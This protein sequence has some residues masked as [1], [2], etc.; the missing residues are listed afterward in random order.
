[1]AL[2]KFTDSLPN[3]NNVTF[4]LTG[5]NE[6]VNISVTMKSDGNTYEEIIKRLNILIAIILDHSSAKTNLSM[7]EKIGKLADLGV[8]PANIARILGKSLNYV[9]ASLS[10]RRSKKKVSANG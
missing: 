5:I 7:A 6:H 2:E 4:E 3:G 9:T 1:M 8:S 10:Q